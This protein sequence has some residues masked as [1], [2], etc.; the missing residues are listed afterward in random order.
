MS[1]LLLQSA[2]GKCTEAHIWSLVSRSPLSRPYISKH[3][4]LGPWGGRDKGSIRFNKYCIALWEHLETETQIAL[5]APVVV[6]RCSFRHWKPDNHVFWDDVFGARNC[7]RCSFALTRKCP[8]S[9]H[10]V[11]APQGYFFICE[12]FVGS[13]LLSNHSYGLA[14]IFPNK[15]PYSYFDMRSEHIFGF[16]CRR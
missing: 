13:S 3:L 6:N 15:S 5:Q 4:C 9:N 12:T 11:M 8:M 14:V 7:C 1:I 2:S 16:L 10:A